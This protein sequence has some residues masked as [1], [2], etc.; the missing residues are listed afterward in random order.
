MRSSND[1]VG[2]STAATAVLIGGDRRGLG[3]DAVGISA[4]AP[5]VLVGG[6][7][8]DNGGGGEEGIHLGELS[9]VEMLLGCCKLESERA[10]ACPFMPRWRLCG[11]SL[12]HGVERCKSD[13]SGVRSSN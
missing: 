1:A 8:D 13:D 10:F 4:A 9:V 3:D 7:I 6:G 11:P 5:A 2:V 12:P